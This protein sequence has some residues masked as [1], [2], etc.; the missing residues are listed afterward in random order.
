MAILVNKPT[1]VSVGVPSPPITLTVSELD[2]LVEALTTDTYWEDQ[3]VTWKSVDFIYKNA[4]G[5]LEKLSFNVEENAVNPTKNFSLHSTTRL[6]TMQCQRIIINGNVADSFVV[7]RTNF[8][9]Q[10]I[11]DINVTS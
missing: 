11:F 3:S 5:Q 8:P 9:T 1:S 6:E 10:N 7:K 2:A 4:S